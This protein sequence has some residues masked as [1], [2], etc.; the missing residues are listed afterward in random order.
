M[1]ERERERER[2]REAIEKGEERKKNKVWSAA[3]PGA[4]DDGVE[5]A[6]QRPCRRSLSRRSATFSTPSPFGTR[7]IR[8]TPEKKSERAGSPLKEWESILRAQQPFKFK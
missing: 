4:V 8:S 2:T 5:V 6:L 3:P 7:R 1:E